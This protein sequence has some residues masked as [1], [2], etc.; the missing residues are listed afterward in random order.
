[1]NSIQSIENV[2]T[3]YFNL[4]DEYFSGIYNPQIDKSNHADL[5]VALKRAAKLLYLSLEELAQNIVDFW[6][7]HGPILSSAVKELNTFNANYSGNITPLEG[8]NFIKRGAL[9]LDSV[10]VE[11]P[12]FILTNTR[13]FVNEEG[14]LHRIVKHV[15]NIYDLRSLFYGDGLVPLLIIVPP[16]SEFGEDIKVEINKIGL[17][18]FNQLFNKDIKDLDYLYN[19]LKNCNSPESVIEKVEDRSLIFNSS[20]LTYLNEIHTSFQETR[21]KDKISCGEAFYYKIFGQITNI[22]KDLFQATQFRSQIVFDSKEYWELYNWNNKITNLDTAIINTIQIND[23][24]KWLG[25]IDL[26]KLKTARN[27]REINDIRNIFRQSL[28]QNVSGLDL[29]EVSKKIINNIEDALAIH[30][31]K[32]ND[33]DKKLKQ[34]YSIDYISILTGLGITLTTLTGNATGILGLASAAYGF[35]D[36]IKGTNELAKDRKL[37]DSSIIG[38]M[39]ESKK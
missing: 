6:H 34:K 36:Y 31:S 13:D 29:S 8:I 30:E 24:L 32:I 16:L 4:L 7:V 12:L 18:Y 20:P 25:N 17:K 38:L 22:S 10:L 23:E 21:L 9:Y 28:F 1:M 15:F 37:A 33:M 35:Y 19:Y 26:D 3:N 2:S 14:F 5:I 27:E 39:F 11:D